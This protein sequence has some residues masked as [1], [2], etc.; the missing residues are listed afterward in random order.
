MNDGAPSDRRAEAT[1]LVPV[2]DAR[3]PAPQGYAHP[4]MSGGWSEG[5]SGFGLNPQ[6]Y[7]RVVYKRKWLIL[8]CILAAIA[9]GGLQAL[10]T[11]PLYTATVRLQIDRMPVKVVEGGNVT[12]VETADN[13][14]LHTEFELI[15]SRAVNASSRS[16]AWPTTPS[17]CARAGSIL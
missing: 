9:L 6:D 4:G 3:L 12:P 13:D 16:H 15:R 8:N 14:F 2:S 5:G 10:V 11:T 7:L 17:S 1:K